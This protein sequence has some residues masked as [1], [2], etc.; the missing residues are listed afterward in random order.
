MELEASPNKPKLSLP[1]LEMQN[2]C[3]V[4]PAGGRYHYFPVRIEEDVV[5]SQFLLFKK[6]PPIIV[7]GFVFFKKELYAVSSDD[8]LRTRIR[9]SKIIQRENSNGKCNNSG[10]SPSST[11]S[12]TTPVGSGAGNVVQGGQQS[13]TLGAAVMEVDVHADAA[14]QEQ[15]DSLLHL[16]S[17]QEGG[18][19]EIEGVA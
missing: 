14:W 17:S 11:T 5:P 4:V 8:I 19:W 10:A 18:E 7:D 2:N 13:A 12:T 15:A 16:I 6:A 3:Y 9:K 1:T